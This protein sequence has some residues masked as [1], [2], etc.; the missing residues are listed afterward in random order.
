MRQRNVN[1]ALPWQVAAKLA[2]DLRG[3]LRQLRRLPVAVELD[4]DAEVLR[5]LFGAK[6]DADRLTE[7][8][9]AQRIAVQIAVIKAEPAGEVFQGSVERLNVQSV[10][11]EIDVA[12]GVHQLAVERNI[13]LQVS[14]GFSLYLQL[15][16]RRAQ[17]LF[18]RRIL[19]IA[20]DLIA[21][22]A[23]IAVD[24]Q[25][26]FQIVRDDRAEIADVYFAQPEARRPHPQPVVDKVE[27][28]IELRHV[29]PVGLKGVGS[30]S[31]RH[32]DLKHAVVVAEGEQLRIAGEEQRGVI[33]LATF[34]GA[35]QIARE[36]LAHQ[37]LR[38]V[39]PGVARV[40]N[41]DAGEN[42]EAR[43]T[44]K[45]LLIAEIAARPERSRLHIEIAAVER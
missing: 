14:L 9:R 30:V 22:A 39:A 32:P 24:Q 1:L 11:V 20:R 18:Q 33:D 2:G 3:H 38:E 10:I 5:I 12:A 8:V 27:I 44:P 43:I 26:L 29:R 23:D 31:Q 40:G 21:I 7:P 17:R 28:D 34:D 13:K 15:L 25:L 4:I 37:R 6:A 45:I 41:A 36:R 35:A 42:V 16:Q 19:E